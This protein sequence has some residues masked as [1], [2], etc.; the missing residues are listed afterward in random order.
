MVNTGPRIDAVVAR[1]LRSSTKAAR[2]RAIYMLYISMI[3]PKIPRPAAMPIM[4]FP[5]PTRLVVSK[6]PPTKT[7][8]PPRLAILARITRIQATMSADAG[9]I[10]VA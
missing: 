8:I 6:N 3:N 9:A 1:I 10:V 5:V 2:P 7:A 4:N